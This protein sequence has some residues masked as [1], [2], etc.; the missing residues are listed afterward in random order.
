[1]MRVLIVDDNEGL[2]TLMKEFLEEEGTYRVRTAANGENGYKAF[3][4]FRPHVVLTDI[5]MPVKNG[6]DMVR[7]IRGHHP[8]I[9]TIYMSGD[10]N[11]Y[12][13]FLEKEKREHNADF[14]DKPFSFREVMK[15][16]HDYRRVSP[17]RKIPAF[18]SP[19]HRSARQRG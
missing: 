1:M 3:L 5:E 10:L 15:L 8:A 11:S 13:I 6:I 19:Y 18:T 4:H 2:T 16:F 17:K 12:R 9:K 14:L 7:E